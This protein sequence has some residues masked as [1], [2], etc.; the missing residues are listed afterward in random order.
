MQAFESNGLASQLARQGAHGMVLV[1]KALRRSV[2]ALLD[3]S[4]VRAWWADL[5]TSPRHRAELGGIALAL[6]GALLPALAFEWLTRRLLRR[7]IFALAAHQVIDPYD[8][9]LNEP[10][11]PASESGA[12]GT[13][14]GTGTVAA[15]AAVNRPTARGTPEAGSETESGSP[16]PDGPFAIPHA[17]EHATPAAPDA[18]QPTTATAKSASNEATGRWHAARHWSLLRR[19][20]RAGLR[21][22]V[23]FVP[24]VVFVGA[25]RA[26]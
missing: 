15:A 2:A 8:L 19:L 20:P 6:L 3:V 7:A 23:R 26:C 5:M 10:S 22:L 1:A 17:D 9:F 18:P 4:S 16:P 24:L 21:M 12:S 11:E 25:W 13:G 14:T